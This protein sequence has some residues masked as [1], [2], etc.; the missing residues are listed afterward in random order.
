M[1]PFF[2]FINSFG[3]LG[4]FLCFSNI[5]NLFWQTPF[6]VKCESF[7]DNHLPKNDSIKTDGI[8]QYSLYKKNVHA[9]FYAQKFNGRKTA[10]GDVFDNQ[11]LTAA[12]RSLPFGTQLRVTNMAN[13]QSIIVYVN[14]RGP[15]V[16]G[17][18]IDL[19]KKGFQLLGAKRGQGQMTVTIEIVETLLSSDIQY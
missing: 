12:H 2:A 19:S 5:P 13:E 9:S 6:L 11:K 10:S 17:R 18:E 7:S 16:K 14:D 1:K 8:Y 4:L 3:T 15:F